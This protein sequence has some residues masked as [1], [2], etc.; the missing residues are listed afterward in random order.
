MLRLSGVRGGLAAAFA[1]LS[2]AACTTASV[3]PSG[4]LTPAPGANLPPV[5]SPVTPAGPGALSFNDLAGWS[6]EDHLG[7]LDAFRQ[8]CGAA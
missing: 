4:P 3:T 6:Q 8:G 5:T 7:A 2:L 1:V